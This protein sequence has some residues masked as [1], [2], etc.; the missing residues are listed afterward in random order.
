MKIAH[1]THSMLDLIQHRSTWLLA[2]VLLIVLSLVA[3]VVLL[4]LSG[5]FITASALAG[6]G[7][8]MGL[9]IFT[10]GAGIRLAAIVRTGSRYAERLVTHEA[11]FRILSDLRIGLFG[12]LARLPIYQQR[13]I[14]RGDTLGRFIQDV[15]KLDHAFLGVVGPSMG[16]ISLTLL[17]SGLIAWALDPRLAWPLLIATLLLQTTMAIWVAHRGAR[18]SKDSVLGMA[19]L[20]ESLVDTIEGLENV[21]ATDQVNDRA[22]QIAHLSDDLVQQ[23]T[24]TQLW[25]A[26]GTSLSIGL[27]GLT[28][29]I[30]LAIGVSFYE[31][32]QIDGPWLGL[33]ALLII[34]VTESWQI[35]PSA[36]RQLS[37]TRQ[38]WARIRPILH[39]PSHQQAVEPNLADETPAIHSAQNFEAQLRCQVHD[40]SFRYPG[41]GIDVINQLNLTLEPGEKVALVGSSGRGKTTLA[42]LLMGELSPTKGSIEWHLDTD[43]G[44]H[45]PIE[46]QPSMGYL[47]QDPKLFSDTLANNLRLAQPTASDQVLV[48]V[49]EKAGLSDWYQ[50]QE[51][52]LETWI[53]EN[54][55]NLSGGEARRVA[56][57]RLM[58]IDPEFVILDEPNTGLDEA[59]NVGINH[60]L[61]VWLS[62]KTALIITHQPERAPDFDRTITLDD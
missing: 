37:Q 59:T 12:Q 61:N 3:G 31:Q 32:G 18:A 21:L 8:L 1:P 22:K 38:A 58:L 42:Y 2:G 26:L 24:K 6:V 34:G 16:A 15:A 20:K 53:D 40:L 45:G 10:P 39:G 54:A 23:Q 35:I 41:S 52:G 4:A 62:N 51:L 29:I 17:G 46:S 33:L 25:D 7:L 36:W 5:W 56:L 47:A 13:A 9:D 27:N 28:L 50:R 60:T 55:T 11:T 44:T 49:L 57:A 14:N 30:T 19:R 48:T 43:D